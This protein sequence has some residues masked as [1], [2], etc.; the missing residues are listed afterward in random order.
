M[1]RTNAIWLKH[2]MAIPVLTAFL[3]GPVLG[4]AGVQELTGERLT[5][6]RSEPQ[7]WPTYFGAY[8]GWRY[9]PLDQIRAE[10]VKSLVPVWVFQTGKIDGGLNA[11]PIVVDGIMYLIASEDRVFGLNAATGERLW[12]YNYKVPRDFVSP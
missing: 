12:T 3:V 7:N 8:D 11:T 2:L 9:S 4:V 1:T 10:N 5:R 6:A